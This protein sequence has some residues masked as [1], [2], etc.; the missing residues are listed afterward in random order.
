MLSGHLR[1]ASPRHEPI[2]ADRTRLVHEHRPSPPGSSAVSPTRHRHG[3]AGSHLT[4]SGRAAGAAVCPQWA[5]H[6]PR[7]EP[8][9][10][11]LPG[12]VPPDSRA[13]PA[14]PPVMTRAAAAAA[15]HRLVALTAGTCAASRGAASA[16]DSGR[17]AERRS[18]YPLTERLCAS[19]RRRSP[20]F[21]RS[22]PGSI[23]SQVNWLLLGFMASQQWLL[24][25]GTGS[26][27]PRME[28]SRVPR[29]GRQSAT[30]ILRVVTSRADR[31]AP[32]R[33]VLWRPLTSP[34][35]R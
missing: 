19:R 25:S 35:R 30:D 9:E 29:H 14:G 3:S 34:D 11:L 28:G 1:P 32:S 2:A 5:H 27:V 16:S 18:R 6:R 12:P 20:G 8:A 10:P 26:R 21:V 33:R 24:S 7:R 4:H 22:G 23:P 15:V 13:P 31:T 17:D